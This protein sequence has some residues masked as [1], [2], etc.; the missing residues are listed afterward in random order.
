MRVWRPC[1]H[2]LVRF[3][4]SGR[5]LS[6]GGH[7]QKPGEAT[8]SKT[9][10]PLERRSYST[11]SQHGQLPLQNPTAAVRLG[12]S[13][14]QSPQHLSKTPL[15]TL[16]NFPPPPPQQSPHTLAL[17]M[18]RMI[19]LRVTCFLPCASSGR[20]DADYAKRL[21]MGIAVII[22]VLLPMEVFWV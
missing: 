16:C 7:A 17:N 21:K 4:C 22:A 10:N 3:A 20:A 9:R 15:P 14:S 12:P 13:Q 6:P 1:L 2:S 18:R 5:L 8:L 19:L 11:S